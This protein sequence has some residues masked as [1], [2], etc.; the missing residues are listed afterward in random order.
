MLDRMERLA[1]SG[2]K[3]A[4]RQ[5]LEELQQMLENLQ[6]A[7]PGSERRRRRRHDV[8]ARRARRHDPQAAAIARPHLPPGPGSAPPAAP[9]RQRAN[10]V[11]KATGRSEPV[12]E[13]RQNQQALREQLKKLLEEMRKRGQPG[14]QGQDSGQ[15]GEDWATL[16]Q[17]GEAMGD[18]EGQL[19]DGDADGAVDA[20]GRALEALRSGAQG[21]AQRCSSRGAGPGPGQSRPHRA[22]ACQPG[23]RSARPAAARA[24][25]WRRRHGEGAGRNRRAARAPHP[26]RVAQALRR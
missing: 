10:R 23:H 1:R 7:R 19:G 5:L 2:A 9:A 13:L 22:G 16:G 26:R 6:M 15:Q 14:Q 4:A 11:S 21:L 12:G 25:L 8:G 24:R 20:Q 18:A 17:A 3:D